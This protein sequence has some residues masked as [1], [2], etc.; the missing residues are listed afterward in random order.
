MKKII[1]FLLICSLQLEL[2][3]AH[4][5][6]S[7]MYYEVTSVDNTSATLQVYMDLYRDNYGGGATF[8]FGAEIGLFGN[9]IF[10]KSYKSDPGN[11]LDLNIGD[12]T[13]QYGIQKTTYTFTATVAKDK[14][15]TFAYLRCCKSQVIANLKF[16]GQEGSAVLL[17]IY[18]SMLNIVHK[19]PRPNLLYERILKVHEENEIDFS[20]TVDNGSMSY[21]FTPI[22]AVGGTA[23]DNGIGDPNACDGVR[24]TPVRCPPPYKNTEFIEGYTYD[25][26]FGYN[27]KTILNQSNGVM[28][29]KPV[30]FGAY[31]FEVEI[32]HIVNGFIR[33]TMYINWTNIVLEKKMLRA[34]GKRYFDQNKNNVFDE[35]EPIYSEVD[36]T[37]KTNVGGI[38]N[39]ANSGKYS[40]FADNKKVY[41]K[42]ANPQFKVVGDS[43]LIDLTQGKNIQQDISIAPISV[44]T[45]DVNNDNVQYIKAT[46]N[47]TQDIV[48]L[49]L[50]PTI[51]RSSVNVFSTTGMN[52]TKKTLNIDN[53]FLNL[54]QVASGMY[55]IT[56]RTESGKQIV[57]KV[58]KI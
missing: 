1:F 37:T 15:Y 43:V 42:S 21:N 5:I 16:P 7:V 30:L 12:Y 35:G 19:G 3:A 2:R 28:K 40:F 29:V 53:G 39:D 17:K 25:Q 26:P 44:N 14:V 22:N 24:P 50:H 4:I 46:P 8:D 11:I 45:T 10:L 49:E 9:N 54:G 56:A 6:G 33:S 18:P 38:N 34:S 41:L 13:G 47:P 58:V 48:Y 57:Q 55:I 32:N 31:N 52:I 20:C 27:Q 23:G 36:L 51:Q